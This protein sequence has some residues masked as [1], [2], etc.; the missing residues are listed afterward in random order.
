MNAM[1]YR[2]LLRKN[3]IKILQVLKKRF[4]FYRMDYRVVNMILGKEL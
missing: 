1:L 2:I 3:L 4:R